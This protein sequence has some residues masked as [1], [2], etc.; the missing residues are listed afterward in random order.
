VTA[1]N[2]LVFKTLARRVLELDDEIHALD[3]LLEPLVAEIVVGPSEH[4]SVLD[5]IACI[6]LVALP[7]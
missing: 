1:A 4:G 2:R 7:Y 5:K 3:G 6:T